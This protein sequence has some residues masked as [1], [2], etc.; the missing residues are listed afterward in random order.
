MLY[1]AGTPNTPGIVSL[2]AGLDFINL[3]GI[4]KAV[5]IK[6]ALTKLI[7]DE[8]KKIPNIIIYGK[9]DIKQRTAVISFNIKKIE[10]SELGY[11]LEESFGIIIRSGLHCAPLIHKSLGSFPLGSVR[12]SPSQF[13]TE[14]EID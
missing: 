10:S 14:E 4:K 1:E 2:N 12:V 13:N 8:F 9:Q 7:L 11:I 3:E 5:Q 6:E